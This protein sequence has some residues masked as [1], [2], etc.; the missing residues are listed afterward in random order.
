MVTAH[1]MITS[2]AHACM[3]TYW[4]QFL[5]I[6]VLA[7]VLQRIAGLVEGVNVCIIA[8]GDHFG[9]TYMCKQDNLWTLATD[10]Q[11]IPCMTT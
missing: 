8:M 4:P 11:S 9:V 7:H 5:L 6:H 2:M 3:T 1:G 10:L